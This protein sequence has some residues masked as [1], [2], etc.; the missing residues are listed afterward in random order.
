M[1]KF[2]A[3][4]LSILVFSSAISLF[5]QNSASVVGVVTD[6][7]GAIVTEVH[8][9]L[10]NTL[11]N[12]S[13]TQNTDNSGAFRFAVVS[14]GS[15]YKIIFSRD[16]FTTVSISDLTLAVAKTR[17][18]NARLSVGSKVETV[19]VS[20]S[21]DNVTINT[22]DATIG[23]NIDSQRTKRSPNLQPHNWHYNSV[24]YAGRR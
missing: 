20:A 9:T 6:R 23:N 8:V 21:D 18:L 5:A 4:F 13:Y 17:T 2:F 11:T 12:E 19:Q 7:T 22:T 10:T 1:H 15:G 24:L 14:P 16:G 3:H